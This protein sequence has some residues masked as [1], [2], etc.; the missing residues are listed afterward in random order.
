[1][2]RNYNRGRKKE[3]LLKDRFEKEGYIVFRTAGSHSDI[4]LIAVK[5]RK[6]GMADLYPEIHFIQVK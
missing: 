4:D 2:N 5:P 6:V 1:M 3:Y